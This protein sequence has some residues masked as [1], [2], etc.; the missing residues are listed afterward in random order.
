MQEDEVL[1]DLR[2]SLADLQV[3]P[4]TP[5]TEASIKILACMR[6]KKIKT[7]STESSSNCTATGLNLAN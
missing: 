1:E 3:Q 7:T 2:D 6:H 5:A 4:R